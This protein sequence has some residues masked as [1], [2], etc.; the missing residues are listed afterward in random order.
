MHGLPAVF[1]AI[2]GGVLDDMFR[3]H[4]GKHFTPSFVFAEK[5]QKTT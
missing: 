4:R 3:N 2:S 1:G 5:V